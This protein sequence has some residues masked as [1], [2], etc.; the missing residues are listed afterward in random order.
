MADKN[1][2]KSFNKGEMI[3]SCNRTESKHEIIL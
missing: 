3:F 1:I 2:L